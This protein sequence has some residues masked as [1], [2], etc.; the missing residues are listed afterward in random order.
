MTKFNELKEKYSEKLELYVPVVG[1]VHGEA[2]P[3]F[4]EVHEIY[5]KINEKIN[6]KIKATESEKP[7]LNEEFKQLRRITENYTIPDDTCESYEAVYNMLSELD[8]A[9]NG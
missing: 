2:H 3:E 4:H 5:K 8:E 1:R 9:Y 6:E 7:E